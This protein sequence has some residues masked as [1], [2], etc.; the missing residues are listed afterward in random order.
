MY[1]FGLS[2]MIRILYTSTHW[3]WGNVAV[4]LKMQS[5][6]T[7]YGLNSWAFLVKLFSGECHKPL[8]WEVNIGLGNGL[9]PCL[10]RLQAI[11]WTNVEPDLCC[12]RASLFTRPQWVKLW[13]ISL[14]YSQFNI[15]SH[16]IIT[17]KVGLWL[18]LYIYMALWLTHW[19][20][21]K[22]A[23]ILKCIFLNEN[24]CIFKYSAVPL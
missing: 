24:Y 16:L 10:F 6:N 21:N 15:K 11:T 7:C 5:Q 22:I 4:I 18:W 3:S 2:C 19:G 1:Y 17:C 8:E 14:T 9:V 12:H 23:T 13:Y 20:L